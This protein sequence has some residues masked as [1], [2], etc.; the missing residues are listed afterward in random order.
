MYITDLK[1]GDEI[2][3]TL[4]PQYPAYLT[5]AGKVVVY[6]TG[7]Q[8]KKSQS[9]PFTEGEA[10]VLLNDSRVLVLQFSSRVNP[11]FSGIAEIDYFSIQ[12]LYLYEGETN[13]ATVAKGLENKQ[14]APAMRIYRKKVILKWK[15]A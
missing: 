11:S 9:I 6:K 14:L 4:T 15:E 5:R 12:S 1:A 8:Y 2:L 13:A 10:S 3:I 7:K